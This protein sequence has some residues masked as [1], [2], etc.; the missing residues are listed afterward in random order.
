[1]EYSIIVQQC[2]RTALFD[3]GANMSVMS[4]MFFNLLP[5][6]LKLLK[7]NVCT[8]TSARDTDLGPIGQCYLTIDW[9][10]NISQTGS[11]FYENC[12]EI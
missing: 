12:S 11:S 3:T 1:M 6:K 4:Q 9:E 7:P 10:I 8:V 5:Q 2:T